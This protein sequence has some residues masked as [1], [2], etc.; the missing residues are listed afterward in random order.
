MSTAIVMLA[1][2]ALM[3]SFNAL[4]VGAEFAVIRARKTRIAELADSGNRLAQTLLPIKSGN[5]ALDN[6]IAACQLGIT[7]SSLVLGAYGQNR[8]ATILAGALANLGYLAV[9][10]AQSVSA[11]AI[12]ILFTTLQV[13]MGEL[14]PKSIA[15]QYPEEMALATTLPVKWSQAVLRPFIWF[16]NGSGNLVL[17]L[18]KLRYNEGHSHIHSPGEIEL[19]MTDSHEGGLIDDK[20]RQML[21]NTCR[22]RELTARQVMVPR[23]RL[24]TA[25]QAST[26]AEVIRLAIEAGFTRI[27]IY[28]TNVDNITGFVHVKDLFPLYLR[29]EKSLQPA[30]REVIYVPET[31]PILDVWQTL[32]HH[33]QY[34]AMVFDEYGGTAGLITFEDLIEEIFGEVEDE[35]DPEMPVLYY[36]DS[37]GRTHLRGD[38]L[39]TDINEYLNLDLPDEFNDTL[40]GLVF[41]LLGRPPREGDEVEVNNLSIRVEKVAGQRISEISVQLPT[42]VT[43]K[44]REWEVAPRD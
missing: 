5:R 25:S 7:A 37:Q 12:L 14:L 38:L 28:Q 44:I 1:A 4:Y 42:N 24:V 43:P 22:L 19:L 35:F 36:Y 30:L 3:I 16:F 32:N 41:S 15:M 27:P 9:P 31:M 6:Y 21:R 29:S 11:T 17:R 40:G 33:R 13:V 18:F 20:E 10:L 39:I 8:V 34:M 26:V 2:T 23:I